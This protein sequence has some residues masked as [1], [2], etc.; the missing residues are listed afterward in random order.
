M[1][2]WGDR[3]QDF[4]GSLAGA[5]VYVSGHGIGLPL[6]PDGPTWIDGLPSDTYNFEPI[7]SLY[8]GLNENSESTSLIGPGS[9][10]ELWWNLAYGSDILDNGQYYMAAQYYVVSGETIGLGYYR[11]KT[12]HGHDTWGYVKLATSLLDYQF[13]IGDGPIT[14]TWDDWGSILEEITPIAEPF[15]SCSWLRSYSGPTG[16]TFSLSSLPDDSD[17]GTVSGTA[18]NGGYI[19]HGVR[20]ISNFEA[21][22]SKG[23]VAW[24]VPTLATLETVHHTSG[25][26][27]EYP[28]GY[29][30]GSL[31]SGTIETELPCYG[32]NNFQTLT[33]LTYGHDAI[34]SGQYCGFIPYVRSGNEYYGQGWVDYKTDAGVTGCCT[35]QLTGS[36]DPVYKSDA[37]HPITE[38][39]NGNALSTDSVH[40]WFMNKRMSSGCSFTSF[41]KYRL[42]GSA[43]WTD[44][45]VTGP[46]YFGVMRVSNFTASMTKGSASFDVISSDFDVTTSGYWTSSLVP[47]LGRIVSGAVTPS[48]N[49]PTV[50]YTTDGQTYG[51]LPTTATNIGCRITTSNPTSPTVF[52][53][54]PHGDLAVMDDYDIP[55][56]SGSWISQITIEDSEAYGMQSWQDPKCVPSTCEIIYQVRQMIEYDGDSEGITTDNICRLAHSSVADLYLVLGYPLTTI[57]VSGAS[58]EPSRTKVSFLRIH[59]VVN[60]LGHVVDDYSIEGDQFINKGSELKVVGVPRP[61]PGCAIPV[62]LIEALALLTAYKWMRT[63]SV[64]RAALYLR[65]Y[66]TALGNFRSGLVGHSLKGNLKS[67][68]PVFTPIIIGTL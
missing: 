65:D 7:G 34:S 18:F 11:V 14:H 47:T 31:L 60:S 6:V 42:S 59:S 27:Y 2:T 4:S 22:V 19:T 17:A 8:T 30:G 68:L 64:D 13:S 57:T 25:W 48:G 43:A 63:R 26:V 9:S 23:S 54:E 10:M 50:T 20:R 15:K 29:R 16:T 62:E 49:W 5:C 12:T 40:S 44:Y 56:L 53:S 67:N 58:T 55:Y 36:V 33:H 38:F 37:Y 39:L 3:L 45:D 66:R 41:E 35:A 28:Y 1:I 61:V 21:S 32:D 52:I 24:R 46:L 51:A